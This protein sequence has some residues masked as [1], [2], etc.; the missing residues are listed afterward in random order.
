MPHDS[1][2]SKL[3]QIVQPI[4]DLKGE[5]FY[6]AAECLNKGDT[7]LLGYNPG[8]GGPEATIGEHLATSINRPGG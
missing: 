2:Q 3:A 4:A 6:S 8:Q 7:Y 1:L 5:V